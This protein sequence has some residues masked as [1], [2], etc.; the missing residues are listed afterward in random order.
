MSADPWLP[1]HL[2]PAGVVIR[3]EQPGDVAAITAVHRAAFPDED[4]A[5]LVELLRASS[6][7]VAELSLVAEMERRIVGHVAVSM[8]I[9]RDHDSDTPIANLS[10]LGVLPD[11]QRRGIGSALVDEVVARAEQRG[12]PLLIVEGD[13]AFYGR[14]GFEYSVP[15]GIHITLPSWARP[16][17]AQMRL[18][19]A[20]EPSLR[21]QVVYPAAFADVG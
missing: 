14:L 2:P 12:E 13:P 6:D 9:L 4:V 10:P 7:W 8:A 11:A 21:G 16:E 5:R 20:I 15:R 1:V 17:C 18:L 19:R 3:A